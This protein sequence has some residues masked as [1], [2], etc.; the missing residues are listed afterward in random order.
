MCTDEN[1]IYKNYISRELFVIELCICNATKTMMIHCDPISYF[2][3]LVLA[4]KK[5]IFSLI[6]TA[7]CIAKS[8]HRRW[9]RWTCRETSSK[10]APR[11]SRST[12]AVSSC[13][14]PST[15]LARISNA[16]FTFTHLPCWPCRRW[17]MVC[18]RCARRRPS[19][20]TSVTTRTSASPADP[21]NVTN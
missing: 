16:S 17:R 8:P 10:P 21:K 18:Y 12:P 7:F 19:L 2:C 3:R 4:S 13:T 14:P 5:S 1:I 9:W 6:H 20:A 11:I 15:P